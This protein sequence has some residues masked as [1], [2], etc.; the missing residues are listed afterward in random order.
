MS[1]ALIG[2]LIGGSVAFASSFIIENF[3][4]RKEKI[5]FKREK[6]EKVYFEYL[7]W[8][9]VMKNMYSLFL[10]YL[11][12]GKNHKDSLKLLAD[13]EDKNKFIKDTNEN[14]IIFLMN[15]YFPNLAIIF[16]ETKDLNGKLAFVLMTN[17]IEEFNL[18]EFKKLYSNFLINIENL[19]KR[20]TISIK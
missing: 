9:K 6:I 1:D 15:L 20:N 3:K 14:N 8:S 17:N 16:Q 2:V 7:N 5:K 4:Q 10:H 13:Y 12:L 11:E 19:D 18:G